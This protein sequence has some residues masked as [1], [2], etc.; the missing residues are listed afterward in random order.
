VYV[1][2]VYNQVLCVCAVCIHSG[3]VCMFYVYTIRYFVYV[4]CLQ[5]L[6]KPLDCERELRH[7]LLK[8]MYSHKLASALYPATHGFRKA[9]TAQ[10]YQKTCH[11]V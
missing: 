10:E 9:A 11:L 6:F 4:L 1:L 8:F 3:I 2:C 7:I 5:V